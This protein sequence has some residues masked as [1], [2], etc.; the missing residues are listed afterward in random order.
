MQQSSFSRTSEVS[1][2]SCTPRVSSVPDGAHFDFERVLLALAAMSAVA[3]FEHEV[4]V[5]LGTPD[6]TAGERV[7]TTGVAD[8]VDRSRLYDA[9]VK[10]VVDATEGIHWSLIHRE[11]EGMPAHEKQRLA[12]VKDGI[13]NFTAD[14]RGAAA[15]SPAAPSTSPAPSRPSC[16]TRRSRCT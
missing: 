2:D 3:E 14:A 7:F 5:L 11:Y 15:A 6:F 8:L 16:G 4:F 10:E 9:Y 1:N 13:K 12:Q